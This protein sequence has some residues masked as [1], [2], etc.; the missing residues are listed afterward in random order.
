MPP[1]QSVLLETLAAAEEADYEGYSKFDGLRSPL[2]RALSFGWWPLRLLWSQ[3]VMR[4]PI[5]LRPLLRVRPGINPEAPALFARANLDAL[6]ALGPVAPFEARATECLAWLLAHHANHEGRYHGPCWGY[7]H[8]WQSTGFYQPPHFPNCYITTIVVGA[9]LHGYRHFQRPA[10]LEAA[11]GAADFILHDL[12]LFHEDEQVKCLA[13][14]PDMR[15]RL[16]VININALAGAMLAEVGQLTGEREL[17]EQARKLLQWV[18]NQQT[19]Y[20]AWY[21]T[22]NPAQSL[23]AH[24]NYHTGMILDALLHYEQAS[25]DGR[26]RAALERGL[27]YY[28]DHLFLPDGAP[29]WTNE[30]RYPHDAHGAGQGTLTFALAGELA[31][32]EQIA[33]W[34]I[35]HLYKG[36]GHFAYQQGRVWT[37]RFTLLHWCDGWMVRGLAALLRIQS[38]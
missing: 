5:N 23:V 3:L 11:R 14:V 21:Y 35:G 9:L 22:T 30:Q 24:D 13:Y 12:P 4:A 32:A 33:G 34:A 25:G 31:M 20:G 37:R 2:T 15:A 26:F 28:R 38:S 36:D 16:Q 6:A 1:I 18:V 7:H 17:L 29:K 8:G 10:Y 19:D 27:A